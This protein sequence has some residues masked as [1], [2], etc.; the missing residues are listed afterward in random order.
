M[1]PSPMAEPTVVAIAANFVANTAL[2]LFFDVLSYNFDSRESVVFPL[3][4]PLMLS[5]KGK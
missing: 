1:L 4:K 2:S 3:L 5:G